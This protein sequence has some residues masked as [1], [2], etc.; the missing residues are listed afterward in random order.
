[1]LMDIFEFAMQ[2]EK[3]GE[4]YYRDL[5]GKMKNDGVKRILNM[6]ADDEVKHYNIVSAM[7]K[8]APEMPDSPVLKNSKNVFEQIKENR[9]NLEFEDSHRDALKKAL[10]VEERSESFYREKE[11]EVDNDAH[12]Q[13][14][15]KLADEERRHVHL[16]DH[17]IE[18]M[19]KPET[20]LDDAEFSNLEEY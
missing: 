16:I 19:M 13:L 9:I 17:M 3:D 20:W 7:R 10:E 12:K 1:M 2:M 5:A 11:D 8:G 6:L 4:E 14:F 18:F 15:K